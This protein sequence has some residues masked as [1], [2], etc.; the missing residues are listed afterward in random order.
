MFDLA[1]FTQVL[2]SGLYDRCS[3]CNGILDA[4]DRC[5]CDYSKNPCQ[6]E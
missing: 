5:D 3:D 6:G 1:N 2:T 4:F